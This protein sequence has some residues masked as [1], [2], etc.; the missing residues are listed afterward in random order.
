[1]APEV[2]GGD[3]SYDTKVRY[4][5]CH[6]I[7]VILSSIYIN[8]IPIS[9]SIQV[10]IWSTGIMTLEMIEG[11][12]PYMDMPGMK[13]LFLIVSQGRPPFK[14][15]GA[16][17]NSLKEFV[18]LSTKMKPEERPSATEFLKV[19]T[20]LSSSSLSIYLSIDR[21]R[22]DS[23]AHIFYFYC[24]QF[25]FPSSILSLI[26]YAMKTIYVLWWFEPNKKRKNQ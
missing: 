11:A 20:S 19:I 22:F 21:Y 24:I 1:M 5:Y 7:S 13:A 18:D 6:P 16:M 25:L 14:N 12:P 8:I 4:Y 15:P 3:A 17:S 26:M 10:D 9:I 23:F 2:I